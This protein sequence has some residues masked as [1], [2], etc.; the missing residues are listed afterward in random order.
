MAR[1]SNI[2]GTG[3]VFTTE[4]KNYILEVLD[5]SQVPVDITGWTINFVVSLTPLSAA[6]YTKSASVSGSYSATRASNT[7]RATATLTDTEQETLT[8]GTYYYSFMR[9]NAG[10][11][12]VLAYG[13]LTLERNNQ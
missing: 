6:L 1:R 4:D 10:G 8:A 3:E 9:T 5:N 2:G 13:W 11:E 7:Q 12:R